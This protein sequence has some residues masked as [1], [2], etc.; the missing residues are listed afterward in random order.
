MEFAE[1]LIKIASILA[2]LNIRYCITGGYAVSVWGRPRS[3]FDIDIVVKLKAKDIA[4]LVK[5]LRSLSQAGYIEESSAKEAVARGKEFN[6]IHSESGIKVDF[7]VIKESDIIGMNEL[8][9]RRAKIIEG[10]KI[11]FISPEDLILSKLRWY[12]ASFSTRHIEDIESILKISGSK[13]DMQY[14]RH[15]AK[16][17]NTER[18]LIKIFK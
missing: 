4:L 6:F 18:I 1:L 7:W 9:R 14:L 13:L 17:Q 3:T 5:H 11:F 2:K 8:K 10:Q 16:M 15:W 12:E